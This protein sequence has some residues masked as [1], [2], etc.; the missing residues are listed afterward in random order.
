MKIFLVEDDPLLI[1]I[2]T[3]KFTMSG[4]EVE[5]A[6]NGEKAVGMIMKSMPDAVVLDLVL[7]HLDGWGVLT[8]LR[9]QEKLDKV[10]IMILS[11]LNQ[12]EDLKRAKD[13]GANAYL[14]KAHNAPSQVVAGVQNMM[15]E[16]VTK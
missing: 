16:I 14:V 3:T 6:D 4:F 1:D 15:Q 13:L 8:A 2:Y 11:N 10:K 5:N 12:D 9:K 7:P